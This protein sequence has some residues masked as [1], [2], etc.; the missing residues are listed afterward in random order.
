LLAWAYAHASDRRDEEC[1]DV[2]SSN[3]GVAGHLRLSDAA[4][5]AEPWVWDIAFD[6]R[7]GRKSSRG[8]APTREAAMQAFTKSWH[9]ECGIL[10]DRKI[11]WAASSRIKAF[12][13]AG[14]SAKL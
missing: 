3:G 10:R 14:I 6:H 9:G 7:E 2:I 5:A 4:P 11:Y 1:Y 8:Y 13:S 12:F